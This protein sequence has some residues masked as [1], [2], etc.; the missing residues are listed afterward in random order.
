[1]TKKRRKNGTHA[2]FNVVEVHKY[3]CSSIFRRHSDA[4]PLAHSSFNTIQCDTRARARARAFAQP[5]TRAIERNLQQNKLDANVTITTIV[6]HR[7]RST[8]RHTLIL[9]PTYTITTKLF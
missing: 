3:V 1:M 6:S 2:I 9:S 7:M 5:L 8:H 4:L